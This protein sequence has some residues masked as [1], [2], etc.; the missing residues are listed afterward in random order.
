MAHGVRAAVLAGVFVAGV[1]GLGCGSRPSTAMGCVFGASMRC[2]CPNG[3]PSTQSCD[4]SNTYGACACGQGTGSV[5]APV[6]ASSTSNGSSGGP[7]AGTAGSQAPMSGPGEPQPGS[8]PNPGEPSTPPAIGTG[9]TGGTGGTM[10]TAGT[11]GMS[12]DGAAGTAAPHPFARCT[13]AAQCATGSACVLSNRGSG[14]ATGYCAPT[15]LTQACPAP[16][17]D[18]AV[19]TTCLAGVCVLGSCQNASCPDGMMCVDTK[20]LNQTV[21]SCEYPSK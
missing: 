3:A 20:V 19:R 9:G 18:G 2:T 1:I 15:C 12:G 11:G 7:G 5:S 4:A 6:G 10:T 21:Y 17:S 14:M 13:S 8:G 16:A